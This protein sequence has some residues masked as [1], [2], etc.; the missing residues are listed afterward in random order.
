[1]ARA[2][3]RALLA[4]AL[5][6][7]AAVA[8]AA[9]GSSHG[10]A[11]G[12]KQGGTLKL[13][14]NQDITNLDPGIA[15]NTLDLTLLNATQRTLYTYRPDDPAH[16][17]PDLAAGPPQISKDGKTLTVKIRSGVRFSP[18][19]SRE[20][21]AKDV[22]YA[23][24]RG[25]NPNVANPYAPGYYAD[26]VGADRAKGGPIAGI[27]TPDARTIVF[28]LVRPTASL[29]AQ[30]TILPLDAPVPPEYAKR[31]DAHAPSDYGSHIVAT[32]PYMLP[33]D[34]SGKVLGTGYVP[35][36]RIRLVRNPNW[37]KSTDDRPAHLDA[38][39]WQIGGAATVSARQALRGHGIVFGEAP[40]AA[41]VK[42]AY[43][44]Y[45]S[46]ISFSPG[47]GS[48]YI[49]LNTQVAPFTNANLRKAL[50]AAL[51]RT[52]M[53][54]VRGGP[55][56]GD[57][58]SHFIYPGV[59]GFEQAGGLRGFGFDFLSHPSGDAALARAYLRKAGYASGRYTG[60]EIVQVVGLTGAP[61]DSDAEIVDQT[62]RDLG[63]KT[64]LKLVD[65][66]VMYARFC[67]LPKARV[68]VC[69]SVGWSRD[70]A[71]P[72]TVLD[73]AF[74]GAAIAPE[75]N[76]NWPQLNDPEINAAMSRAELTVGTE[77][78]AKAWAEID[79]MITATAAAIPWLWDK[80]PL[81]TSRD[82]HC[83]REL[84]NQGNCDFGYSS[85]E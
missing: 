74:N 14:T 63:F 57:I 84:W 10:N 34:R 69:T 52:H 23:I 48:R 35:G 43:Q 54:L 83:V 82:V 29:L 22:K 46:Q 81:L 72:Q 61:D 62:L 55:I 80:Q 39:T 79:R 49:A 30:A 77:A 37:R 8:L 64:S 24:E 25:F 42:L 32:G 58:A 59:L 13:L 27:Q 5:C 44:H 19:V 45:R 2:L 18:P 7:T 67:A 4:S 68:Q 73:A 6:T 65:T 38:V 17:A 78:R 9:C 70:F 85:L 75:N 66:S 40:P 51:D 1:M 56:T 76:S 47:A 31:F 20:V 71:D 53:R 3:V 41:I 50:A 11:T 60:N 26:I 28:K 21:T 16:I 15:Y 12:G 33:A 36:R